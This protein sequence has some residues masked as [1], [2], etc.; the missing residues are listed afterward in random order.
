MTLTSGQTAHLLMTIVLLLA[1]AHLVGLAFARARLP[2][3]I[4]EIVGGLLLGPTLLGATF[5]HV[6]GTMFPKAGVTPAVLGALYQLGLIL[7][8]FAAG[9]RLGSIFRSGERRTAA[10]ITITGV[11]VPFLAGILVFRLFEFSSFEGSAHSVRALS[12]VFAAGIAVTSIPVI[13]RIM[14]DLDIV[15]TPFARIVLNA[16]V[17][18]DVILYAILAIAVGVA[19]SGGGDYGLPNVLGIDSAST[20]GAGYYVAATV[21]IIVLALAIR[22]LISRLRFDPNPLSFIAPQLLVTLSISIISVLLGVT[23]VFGGLVAGIMIGSLDD[24][25]S[26]QASSS[27][28]KFAFAFFIPIYFAL[29][30]LRLDLSGFALPQFMAFLAFACAVKAC[31]V[32]VGARVS[33]EE[34]TTSQNLAV[35]MNARGGP[36]IVLASVAFDAHI[37][38]QRFY[39]YLVVLSI[40]TSLIAGLWLERVLRVGVPL[41]SV[42]ASAAVQPLSVLG[43]NKQVDLR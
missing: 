43:A 33:G 35:A 19:E 22:P 16:A 36:G 30:G 17:I 14:I 23:L 15:D 25:A 28:S 21:L 39:A 18:E 26:L 1:A 10:V 3:V 9:A 12:L 42:K 32:Y 7:L 20:G 29:V 13:S 2:R 38:N 24:D 37:I 34:H 11:L 31:G 4:G 5:P 40:V 41:R 8:M 27:I 6:Y